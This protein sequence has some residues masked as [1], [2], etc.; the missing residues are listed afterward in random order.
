MMEGRRMA[1]LRLRGMFPAFPTPLLADATL[2]TRTLE[3]LVVHQID[4]GAAGLVPVGGTGEA[5]SL[6]AQMRRRIVEVTV[7]VAARRVPVVAGVL[8]PGLGGVLDSAELYSKAGADGLMI[9][10]PYYARPDQA[11]TRRYFQALAKEVKLPIVLYDNPYRAHVSVA[12]DMIAAMADDRLIVGMKA[13]STDLHHFDHVARRVGPEFGLLSGQD[14]LFVQQTLLGAKGGVL[15]S[16][17]LMP[18]YW[19][20]I[21]SDVENGRIAQALEAQRRLYPFLDVLFAE[22]FPA[23]VRAAFAMLGLP[24]GEGIA[25]VGA[26]SAA[27]SAKLEGAIS[28]LLSAGLLQRLR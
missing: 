8:D 28:Y 27:A 2:D 19:N 17:C 13:S 3:R 22:E 23:G 11:A 9:I 12:P 15:T 6:T 4:K 21:Q 10:P 7:A 5:T 25:P 20:A 16:A 26:F 24:I 1:E 18:N 14:T